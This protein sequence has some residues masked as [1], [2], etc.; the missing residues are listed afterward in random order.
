MHQMQTVHVCLLSGSLKQLERKLCDATE[1]QKL[2]A[3][4]W[5]LL[6]FGTS[7]QFP[8]YKCYNLL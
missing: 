4:A 1:T 3:Q 5:I 6:R 2:Q 7:D 8:S